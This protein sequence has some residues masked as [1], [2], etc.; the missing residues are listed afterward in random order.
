MIKL[1]EGQKVLDKNGNEYLTEQGD[2]IEL[3]EADNSLDNLTD[4]DLVDKLVQF[5]KTNP[6]PVDAEYHKFAEENG[7]DPDIVESYAYAMLTVILTGG[8]S[9]GY[10]I[11]ADND[12]LDIGHEIEKEH[13]ELDIDNPVVKRMQHHFVK[14][15]EYD[16]LAENPNYYIESTDFISEL[17]KENK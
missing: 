2:Y 4:V 6:F 15:I 1:K 11:E 13:V 16:H 14:K 8:K 3:R 10:V 9:K 7:Y 17:E 5:I 12:N